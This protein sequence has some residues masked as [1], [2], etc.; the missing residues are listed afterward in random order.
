MERVTDLL[1]K[2]HSVSDKIHQAD[3][4][5]RTRGER[6]NIFSVMG[7]NHYELAHSTIIAEFLDPDGSHGQG[8]TFLDEFLDE[9]FYSV[10]CRFR[11]PWVMKSGTPFDSSSS[12][13][14]TE[15][16]TDDGRI[17]IL[18]KNDAGQA[19]IIENK[20]YA[21]DRPRQLKRYAEFAERQN[22]DYS[23]VYLTLYG[24]EASMQSAEGVDYVCI[25]YCNEITE[26]L[27]RCIYDAV[28]KPFLREAFIQY[29]N[30]VKI[31]THQDME[32]KFTEEVIRAMVDN[33]EA[34]SIICDAQQKYQ[35]YVRDNILVPKLKGFADKSGLQFRFDWD[36]NGEKGFYFKRKEWKNAAVWF[37]SESR[38]SWTG[39]YIAVMNE[40]P[41]VPLTTNKQVQLHCFDGDCSDA[42]PFGW[43]YMEYGYSEWNMDT[44]ADIVNGKFV[45]YVKEQTLAVINE[46]EGLSCFQRD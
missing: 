32:T 5:A 25:S 37:Y 14:Y 22:W 21:A 36:L 8:R 12:K 39:F 23:I 24:S 41:D 44:F 40:Y 6:F 33:A 42:Y 20:L 29:S 43:K 9:I 13:V 1:L 34:A 4:N 31:I 16:D 19:I 17:D 11:K 28:D 3:E 15:Y 2:I 27:Q 7:V 35:E 18:I 10:S 45:E 26:W 30:L 38:T 46:L